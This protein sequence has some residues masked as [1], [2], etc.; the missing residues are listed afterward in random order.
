MVGGFISGEKSADYCKFVKIGERVHIRNK[1][2]SSDI[3]P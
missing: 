1:T 3:H 2:F